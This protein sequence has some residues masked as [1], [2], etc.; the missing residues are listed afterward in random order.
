MDKVGSP[1]VSS[2]DSLKEPVQMGY[3]YMGLNKEKRI[4][5]MKPGDISVLDKYES[6]VDNFFILFY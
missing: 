4:H 1:T 5:C 2:K 6:T 3:V